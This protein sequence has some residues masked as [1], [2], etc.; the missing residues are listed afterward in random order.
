MTIWVLLAIFVAVVLGFRMGARSKEN[1]NAKVV[2]KA[3]ATLPEVFIVAD[4]ETTG[5]HAEKN[6]IIEIAAIRVHRDATE[7]QTFSTLVLSGKR[8]PEKITKITG[9]T[10]E[11]TA[12]DGMELGQAIREF[13]TF[14]GDLRIV[15]FNAPFDTSFIQRAC[16]K[17]GVQIENP[18]SCAL[19][20]ARRAWP[21]RKS[22]S[23]VELAND[24]RLNVQGMHRA[25][26]DCQLTVTVYG[27]AAT[28]LGRID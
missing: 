1:P 16:E 4:L 14:V 22:Y 24:G 23:L 18:V 13:K 25:L 8:I 28:I 9:I 7:H 20:M 21:N 26:K 15:F 5:L 27:A 10:N 3:R 19:N 2:A 12:S 6:E 17:V 11:M